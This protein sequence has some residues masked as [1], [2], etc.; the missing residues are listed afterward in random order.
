MD[1]FHKAGCVSKT[2]QPQHSQKSPLDRLL[3]QVSYA[4]PS[5]QQR[6]LEATQKA[7]EK[8][9]VFPKPR[10]GA[11]P[12]SEIFSQQRTQ[13]RCPKSFVGIPARKHA[14]Q[15]L[16]RG[17]AIRSKAQNCFFQVSISAI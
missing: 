1:R 13:P 5:P 10:N 11:S 7:R 15:R 2:P 17:G 9:S 14:L 12:D 6:K 4:R 3:D 16:C 8:V